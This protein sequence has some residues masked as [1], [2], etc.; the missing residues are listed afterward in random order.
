MYQIH[1]LGK[2]NLILGFD[3]MQLPGFVPIQR[4]KASLAAIIVVA[5]VIASA[6]GVELITAGLFACAG[7][8]IF[9][10]LTPRDAMV[11]I[12]F[13]TMCRIIY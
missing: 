12:T 1:V 9:R 3:V 4:R 11:I 10:C 13:R 7:L 6:I 8:L 2:V 5:M